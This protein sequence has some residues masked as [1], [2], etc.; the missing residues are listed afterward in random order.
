MPTDSA[1]LW[2][3][4]RARQ[5]SFGFSKF[6]KYIGIHASNIRP[7]GPAFSVNAEEPEPLLEY[8]MPDGTVFR[9]VF[10]ARCL[11]LTACY[12]DSK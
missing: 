11:C 4:D 6:L 1:Q 10:K 7:F 9:E 5:R 3:W 2:T 8:T 12:V